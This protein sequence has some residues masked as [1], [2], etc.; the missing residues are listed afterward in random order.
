MIISGTGITT[1]NWKI[2]PDYQP[3]TSY[4][5]MSYWN[6]L[7][8]GNWTTVDRGASCDAYEVDIRLYGTETGTNNT[9]SMNNFVAQLEANRVAGS[10]IVQ[11]SGFNSQEHVFGADCDYSGTIN[12]TAII[13]NRNQNTLRGFGQALR[14]VALQPTFVGGVGFLPALRFVKVGYSGDAS[15]TIN[16]LFSYNRTAFYQEH[17][18]DIGVWSGTFTFDDI[19]MIALRRFIATQRVA[20]ISLTPISGVNFPFGRRSTTYPYNVK[21]VG[22]QD[23]GMSDTRNW[24][25]TLAFAEQV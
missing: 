5:F 15:R 8:N 17:A 10:N 3:D 19:E 22:F 9:Q 11:L 2:K 23:L 4:S 12:A 6:Q 14:L 25:V 7:S 20:T 18:S 21:I 16:K 13:P 24:D 1:Q